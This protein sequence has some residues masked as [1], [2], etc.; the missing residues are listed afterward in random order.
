M[1]SAIAIFFALALA[2]AV[3]YGI[4]RHR[5]SRKGG[6]GGPWQNNTKHER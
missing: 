6:S 2:A 3:V 5:D 1:S 4:K